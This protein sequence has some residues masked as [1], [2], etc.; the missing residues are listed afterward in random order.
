MTEPEQEPGASAR[1]AD[2]DTLPLPW[3]PDFL[4]ALGET[5]NVRHSARLAGISQTTAYDARKAAP[6]FAAAWKAAIDGKE[7]G[8]AG[9][10]LQAPLV[11][12]AAPVPA[13]PPP[14]WCVCF[15]A[16]LAET[17]SV[18]AAAALARVTPQN[19]YHRR[20]TDPEFAAQW[21][22]ALHEGYD[23]LEMELVGYLRG[24]APR[25]KMDVAGA[26][27]LLA[28][29]RETV[30]RRRALIE[31]EDEQAVLDSIDRF[32]DDMRL[33]RAANDAI[34]IEMR[35]DDGAD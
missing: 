16:A 11:A 23:H 34:V 2:C 13:T 25:R 24:H 30:E 35:A 26:L 29:H 19:A 17:S 5:G 18:I 8:R 4:A 32:I 28:A 15:L 22:A 21:L 31:E 12:P 33:R 10:Q 3:M 1:A 14:D 7:Y 9:F 6:G 20:R 27:R